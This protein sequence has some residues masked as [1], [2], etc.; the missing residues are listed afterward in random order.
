MN[1]Y[2]VFNHKDEMIG[3]Y[4]AKSYSAAMK[5]ASKEWRVS[6]DELRAY[7]A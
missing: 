7:L 5:A 1:S 2:H 6:Y 3:T 4:R